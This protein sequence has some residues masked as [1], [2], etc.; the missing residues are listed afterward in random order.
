MSRHIIDQIKTRSASA[1]L[2]KFLQ[3]ERRLSAPE[4]HPV[5]ARMP[6]TRDPARKAAMF[7]RQERFRP[8]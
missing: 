6:R 8:L 7:R 1:R 4:G 3:V 5:L 2:V